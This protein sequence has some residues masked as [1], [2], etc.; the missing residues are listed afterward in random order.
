[1]GRADFWALFSQKSIASHSERRSHPS[2]AISIISLC[3]R[4]Q[5]CC[6]GRD[7][8]LSQLRGSG[9]QLEPQN[10]LLLLLQLLHCI[11]RNVLLTRCDRDRDRVRVRQ[12]PGVRD[13][14]LVDGGADSVHADDRKDCVPDDVPREVSPLVCQCVAVGIGR[15]AAVQDDRRLTR[16]CAGYYLISAGVGNGRRWL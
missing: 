14:Q 12:C 2:P 1:M 5:C 16:A 4:Q 7:G 15:C 8:A 13:P 3:C 10:V 6:S 9:G 11:Q